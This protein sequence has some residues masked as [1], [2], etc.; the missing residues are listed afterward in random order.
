VH[1]THKIQLVML[2]ILFGVLSLAVAPTAQAQS[3]RSTIRCESIHGK[4]NRCAVPWRDAELARQE[5]KGACIRGQGWGMDRQGLWVDRGCRGLFVQARRGHGSQRGDG[6]PNPGW[7]RSI[8][9][10]C[11]SSRCRRRRGCRGLCGVATVA[12]VAAVTAFGKIALLV[13]ILLEVGFVPAAAGQPE[14]RRTDHPP[15]VRRI[16]GGTDRGIRI[17]QLLQVVEVVTATAAFKFVDG[18]ENSRRTGHLG[19]GNR[20]LS[21]RATGFQRPGWRMARFR[22]QRQPAGQHRA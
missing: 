20:P 3:D 6:R 10:E 17:G 1:S 2:T 19:T 7:D 21:A 4:F 11:G 9:L 12:A 16:A 8:T 14:R 18:H 13:A 22:L 15:Q 5:S